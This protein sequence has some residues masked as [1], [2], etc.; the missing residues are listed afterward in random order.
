MHSAIFSKTLF[1]LKKSISGPIELTFSGKT[2]NS[3]LYAP[4]F[5]ECL[6]LVKGRSFS[7]C[8]CV[9]CR[10][11]II[12]SGNELLFLAKKGRSHQWSFCA[13]RRKQWLHFEMSKK[14]NKWKNGVPSISLLKA[15]LPWRSTG[16]IMIS[17]RN[18]GTTTAA[19]PRRVLWAHSVRS[20]SFDKTSGIEWFW[21]TMT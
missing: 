14:S 11:W 9:S 10:L 6:F 12:K 13:W 19:R 5:L 8:G 16:A 4:F 21:R 1:D 18:I 3:I 7:F 20:A 17:A 2:L 15:T